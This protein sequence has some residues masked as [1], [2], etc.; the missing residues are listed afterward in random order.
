MPKAPRPM[1]PVSLSNQAAPLNTQPLACP[2]KPGPVSCEL[3]CLQ[4]SEET[5]SPP[6]IKPDEPQ[7]GWYLD[8]ETTWGG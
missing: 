1:R 5:T 6:I 8:Y 2:G 7:P 4:V 3:N